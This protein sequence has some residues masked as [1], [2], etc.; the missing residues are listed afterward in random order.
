MASIF[1]ALALPDLISFRAVDLALLRVALALSLLIML[2]AGLIVLHFLFCF[3]ARFPA[4]LSNTFVPFGSICV[5]FGQC[6][7]KATTTTTTDVAI[8]NIFSLLMII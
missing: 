8:L 5:V 6:E 4:I 3:S 2:R 7:A 1:V